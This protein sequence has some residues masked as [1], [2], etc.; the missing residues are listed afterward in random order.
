VSVSVGKS[1]CPCLFLCLPNLGKLKVLIASS[2]FVQLKIVLSADLDKQ[3]FLLAV[4]AMQQHSESGAKRVHTD[5]GDD[6][7]DDAAK[8]PRIGSV[9]LQP[10]G[11]GKPGAALSLEALEKA[12]RALQLQKE[13]KEKL[14]KLPQVT[15]QQNWAW[16]Q[17]MQ[18]I[19]QS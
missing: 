2:S 4:H 18:S 9:A 17:S 7:N 6:D 8:R 3:A 14:K 16:M 12:K 10:G 13:L 19:D 1:V 5:N 11:G 15:V